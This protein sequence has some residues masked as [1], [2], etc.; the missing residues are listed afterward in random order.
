MGVYGEGSFSIMKDK[1]SMTL[2]YMWPWTP[3]KTA[4]WQLAN[5]QD[6]FHARLVVQKGLIPIFDVAGAIFYDKHGLVQSIRDDSFQFLDANT[7]FG[8]EL[9]IPV[10]KTP[11][12]DVAVIFA[13]VPERNDK[14]G[15]IVLGSDGLPTLKPS[16]SFETRLHF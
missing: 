12:L 13:A 10:P 11:M 8:G 9:V 2:G 16:I 1:L 14:S 7:S 6:E 4:T 5:A 3:G 15:Q